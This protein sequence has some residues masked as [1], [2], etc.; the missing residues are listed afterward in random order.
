M[1]ARTDID[2]SLQGCGSTRDRDSN[3]TDRS[4]DYFFKSRHPMAQRSKGQRSEP[5]KKK[6]AQ[7]DP[8]AVVVGE[9]QL[10]QPY[11][12]ACELASVN[13]LAEARAA[14]L[15]I[16]SRSNARLRALIENDLAVLDAI[17]GKLEQARE[18]WRALVVL[19]P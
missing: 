8:A 15:R 14:Y 13:R 11:W 6:R 3:S 12:N 17:E 16:N 10:P 4:P 19:H 1:Y 2:R 7:P 9:P 18:Q 5:H